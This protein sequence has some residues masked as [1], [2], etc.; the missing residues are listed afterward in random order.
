MKF[1]KRNNLITEGIFKNGDQRKQEIENRKNQSPED[2][3]SRT[4]NTINTAI[5]NTLFA[6]ISKYGIN[7]LNTLA[8]NQR[9]LI[10]FDNSLLPIER[11]EIVDKQQKE[12]KTYIIFDAYIKSNT[13]SIQ[14]VKIGN[15]V[16]K[17]TMSIDDIAKFK[18]VP[19]GYHIHYSSVTT[20]S[21]SATNDYYPGPFSVKDI[22]MNFINSIKESLEKEKKTSG[23]AAIIQLLLDSEL[24]LGHIHLFYD[25]RT[26]IHF[27]F[28]DDSFSA[29][30]WNNSEAMLGF[31]QFLESFS[32]MFTF[33]NDVYF[34]T[35]PLT[36]Y[37][38]VYNGVQYVQG[39]KQRL[40]KRDMSNEIRKCLLTLLKFTSTKDFWEFYNIVPHTND[41]GDKKKLQIDFNTYRTAVNSLFQKNSHYSTEEKLENVI[42]KIMNTVHLKYR[43]AICYKLINE[44][45]WKLQD[46]VVDPIA[47]SFVSR[48]GNSW[49]NYVISFRRNAQ[50]NFCFINKYTLIKLIN[51]Y[52]KNLE[53]P[54]NA[55]YSINWKYFDQIKEN[56][57]DE[58]KNLDKQIDVLIKHLI[59]TR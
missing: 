23:N 45:D 13:S 39:K 24:V 4:A 58:L 26:P 51:K 22:K 14:G 1:I 46:I 48:D 6:V 43:E 15:S 34:S 38:K 42:D 35:H 16:W 36:Q 21:T 53:V 47:V 2:I 37:D 33:N 54:N 27:I 12:D 9:P 5:S 11:I 25:I 19:T 7:P 31:Q 10:I 18:N 59:F 32:S 29:L 50:D 28:A 17:G 52:S 44:V 57:D 56:L 8:F 20:N 49:G 55:F 3:A 41:D 40:T 30:T